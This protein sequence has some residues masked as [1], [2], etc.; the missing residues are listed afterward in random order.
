MTSESLLIGIG[1][2]LIGGAGLWNRN[3]LLTETPKGRFLV[4]AVGAGWARGLITVFF[5]IVMGAGIL[6]AGGWLQ[7]IRW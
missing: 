7:P 1:S 5:V 3:W 2:A 4:E 6:L